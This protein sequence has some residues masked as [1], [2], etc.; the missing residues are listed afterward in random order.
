M[1]NNRQTVCVRTAPGNVNMVAYG[2]TNTRLSPA[3]VAGDWLML[4]YKVLLKGVLSIWEVIDELE[5]VAMLYQYLYPCMSIKLYACY[6][7]VLEYD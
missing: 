1:L 2:K 6:V 3:A 7:C 5:P 4:L